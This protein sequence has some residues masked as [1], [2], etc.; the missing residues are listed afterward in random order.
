[1]EYFITAEAAE[2][3][4]ISGRCITVLCDE[5]GIEGAFRKGSRW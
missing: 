5:G 4:N 2:K 3:W 1:M